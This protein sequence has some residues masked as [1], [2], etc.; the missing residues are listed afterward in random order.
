MVSNWASGYV[1]DLSYTHGY[2]KELSPGIL[3]FASL[4]KG[5]ESCIQLGEGVNY[6]E[7]GCGQGFSINLLAAANVDIQ[8]YATDFNPEQ[9]AGAKKLAHAAGTKNVH[10]FDSSFSEFEN[11]TQLPK[12]DIIALHGIYSWVS[13]EQREIIVRF[14]ERKLKPGGLVYVSYNC[15]PGWV[16]VP[17]LRHLM[18]MQASENTGSIPSKINES[19]EFIE[20]LNEVEARYFTVNQGVHKRFQGLKALSP[21]Y[22][23]HEYFN[24][25]WN[26]FYH[27]DVS[28]ELSK[29]RLSY[30]ASAHLLDHVDAINL[31]GKQVEFLNDVKDTSNRETLRDYIV[32][33]Q[34]RRDI[35]SRGAI[36][37]SVPELRERWLD[38]YF[39]LTS[40]PDDIPMKVKG[41]LGEG[42]LQEET[43]KPLIG[44]FASSPNAVSLRQLVTDSKLA[45]LGW[46]RLQEAITL[47]VGMGHLVPCWGNG[48]PSGDA[49]KKAKAFNNAVLDRA[50]YSGDLEYLASPVTGGAVYVDR[51]QQFFIL[52]LKENKESPV[53]FSLSVLRK[54]NQKLVKNGLVIES[55][56]DTREELQK[57]FN[58]FE[59][60]LHLLKDL[61]VI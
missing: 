32:N 57:K 20:R 60:R 35:F 59:D 28:S 44:A 3:R 37:F 10:F 51:V 9:I 55:A 42:N 18:R 39:T 38:S 15:M 36:P 4:A 27:S 43:Y 34:F 5:L 17:P 61:G 50:M 53:E 1:T 52:S 26:I 8:F 12:F 13:K 30:I 58:L 45:G 24:E 16:N 56:D 7:L 19:F 48:S 2:Y 23:A 49:L 25:D 14:I 33:Q 41:I 6:C 22:L 54:L 11:N 21:N 47:L 31:T 29:A 40:V 46:T